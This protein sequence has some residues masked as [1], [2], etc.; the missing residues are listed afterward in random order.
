MSLDEL[1]AVL[2]R[3]DPGSRALLDLSLRRRIS[4]QQIASLLRITPAEVN[5]RRERVIH[6]L[7][8]DLGL[9]TQDELIELRAALRAYVG[10]DAPRP[11]QP[12]APAEPE[13]E[14]EEAEPEPEPE[15]PEPEERELEP[16]PEEREPEPESEEPEPEPGLPEPGPPPEPGTIAPAEPEPSEPPERARG[17]R[18][19]IALLAASAA[20][21]LIVVVAGGG[22]DEDE[23]SPTTGATTPTATAPAEPSADG[24]P[25]ELTSLREGVSGTVQVVDRSGGTVVE[26]RPRGLDPGTYQVWLYDTVADAEPVRRFE[27]APEVVRLRLPPDADQRAFLDVSAEPDDGN[28]NHS[29][30]SVLRIPVGDLLG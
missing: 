7:A 8:D 26:L 22:D 27:G 4:D 3:L 2:E 9:T 14:P 23:G 25:L 19:L 30:G 15:E 13:P 29:G 11:P 17:G 21:V 20:I 18:A 10:E 28:P 5:E 6:G 1:D 24:E 12:R 16:E